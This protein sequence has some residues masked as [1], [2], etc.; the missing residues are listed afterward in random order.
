M[1]FYASHEG[2]HLHYEAQTLH[3][4]Q[5]RWYNLSARHGSACFA[6]PSTGRT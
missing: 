2:L 4:R 6:P 3:P 1:D 5:N